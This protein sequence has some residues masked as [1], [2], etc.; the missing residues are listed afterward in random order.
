MSFPLNLA[1]FSLLLFRVPTNYDFDI[2]LT[3]GVP[4][5]SS[6]EYIN[7]SLLFQSFDTIENRINGNVIETQLGQ[8]ALTN[9]L[10]DSKTLYFYRL[11]TG[12]SDKSGYIVESY[13][14]VY[15][16]KTIIDDSQWRYAKYD[17]NGYNVESYCPVYVSKTI[18]DD[19]QW[20]YAKYDELFKL[21]FD[22]HAPE[23][24]YI[25]FV[26][27]E[28][29]GNAT[30][31]RWLLN[32]Y[33]SDRFEDQLK[34]YYHDYYYV[35]NVDY[36]YYEPAESISSINNDEWY[37]FNLKEIINSNAGG[38]EKYFNI[39]LITLPTH[40]QENNII[41]INNYICFKN[42]NNF[43]QVSYDTGFTDGYEQGKNVAVDESLWIYS[44]IRSVF[45][46]FAQLLNVEILP[47]IK[48]GY[49]IAIPL[50][51]SVLRFIL[52]FFKGD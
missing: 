20:R 6:N 16:S 1:M 45:N 17:E 40:K 51:L 43:S 25:D 37:T 13:C 34:S 22:Y 47:N 12:I 36:G 14:P 49:L 30:Q 28:T 23:E 10:N 38:T 33:Y 19:S 11:M 41:Q 52:G 35:I 4:N 29:F 26:V 2:V 21:V 31:T 27:D 48:L 44:F 8:S 9:N 24:L 46:G 7:E 42:D 5:F 32:N 50:V 18:I 39:N 15:V 3:T